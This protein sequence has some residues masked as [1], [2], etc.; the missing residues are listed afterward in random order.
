MSTTMQGLDARYYLI[1]WM[2]GLVSMFEADIKAIPDAEWTNARGGCTRETHKLVA[3]AVGMLFWVASAIKGEVSNGEEYM[4]SLMKLNESMTTKEAA[5]AKL[6]EGA[7][8]LAD[9]VNGASDETLN[10]KVM[11]PWGME[12]PLFTMA[13]IAVNHL[14]YHDGQLNYV[15]CLLGDDKVHWMM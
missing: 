7:K 3:D 6:H 10:S 13:H 1:G 9:A 4:G 11:A 14:W 5:I 15:Q 12:T 2:H 8:T